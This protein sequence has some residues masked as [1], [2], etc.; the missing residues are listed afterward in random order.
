[1]N[2]RTT[3]SRRSPSSLRVQAAGRGLASLL[4]LGGLINAGANQA[5]PNPPKVTTNGGLIFQSQGV[6]SPNTLSAYFFTPLSQGEA[7][8]LLFVDVAANL[9]LGGVLTQPNTVNAG[10]STRLGYRWLSGDQRWMYGINAGV[11]TRQAYAQYAF[12]AGVGGEALSRSVEL[13]ANGYIPFSNK[14]ELYTSGWSNGV[15][16]GNQLI[17]DGWNRYVVSLSGLNLEAGVPV[18]RWNQD[19]N[20]LWL[21]ASYYY[22]DGSYITGSSGVRGRAEMRIGS[23]L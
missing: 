4:I 19:K 5:K 22:L 15:L 17:V 6:G 9:N 18:G 14:A 8:E 2:A 16:T 12:Q 21:Y 7:G 23:Q 11:D 3:A 20:S 10:A 13:R 1:M